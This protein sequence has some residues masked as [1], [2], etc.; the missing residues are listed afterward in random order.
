MPRG[1]FCGSKSSSSSPQKA[2]SSPFAIFG[3]P[4]DKACAQSPSGLPIPVVRVIEYI[5]AVGLDTEGIYRVSGAY[6]Q[7]Q[8]FKKQF[9]AGIE[10]DFGSA[11]DVYTVAGVLGAYLRDLPE[12]LIPSSLFEPFV[13]AQ[14]IDNR[15]T[16]KRASKALLKSLPECNFNVLKYLMGHLNRI[17]Q[18]TSKNKMGPVNLGIVFGPSVMRR[19][20]ESLETIARDGQVVSSLVQSWIEEYEYFFER[21]VS[22]TLQSSVPQ[23]ASVNAPVRS[24]MDTSMLLSVTHTAPDHS[25]PSTAAA[26]PPSK[27][28]SSRAGSP[29]S[30]NSVLEK[31]V[32]SLMLDVFDAFFDR[33]ATFVGFLGPRMVRGEDAAMVN[34]SRKLQNERLDV[35]RAKCEKEVHAL[36]LVSSVV[37]APPGA[38]SSLTSKD[39]AA[40][41]VSESQRNLKPQAWQH[42]FS[43]QDLVR[44]P[45]KVCLERLHR[46]RSA[47]DRTFEI[48]AMSIEELKAE[49]AAV[50][51]ELRRYDRVFSE[52]HQG[53]DPTKSEKEPLRPLYQRYKLLKQRL[54]GQGVFDDDVPSP[55]QQHQQSAAQVYH[56]PVRSASVHEQRSEAQQPLF[57]QSSSASSTARSSSAVNQQPAAEKVQKWLSTG[58]PSTST[59]GSRTAENTVSMSNVPLARGASAPSLSSA[60]NLQQRPTRPEDSGVSSLS[61]PTIRS[62]QPLLPSNA[63]PAQQHSQSQGQFSVTDKQTA[64][65]EESLKEFV[66]LRNEKRSLQ[67][68][69]HDYQNE[70]QK[71]Y[72]RKVQYRAD[73]LPMEKEYERYKFLRSRV[74]ELEDWL[75][76][77][78]VP[79]P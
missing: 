20:V 59:A 28:P 27:S 7:I 4:L 17:T 34:R 68:Q 38:T 70:F 5:D 39:G 61:G 72:N 46:D 76:E 36:D 33:S 19:A 10:P 66:G 55:K 30:R 40:F 26:T 67:K 22:G 69:L 15:D 16:R 79:I 29:S 37:S 31:Q 45:L 74:Q 41:A 63:A 54:E 44:D 75:Q 24:L 25:M 11:E 73:R 18:H 23:N 57:V 78:K 51:K 53:R 64:A 48:T 8:A 65:I 47:S 21:V 2:K 71:R 1:I 62:V 3:L 58:P 14:A 49:K 32:T 13:N 35:A 52:L 6:A 43:D 9:M 56:S 60:S 50:K 12:P 77:R 42:D